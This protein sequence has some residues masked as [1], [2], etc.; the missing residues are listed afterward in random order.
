MSASFVGHREQSLY[1]AEQKA[2]VLQ[3]C[4]HTG[5]ASETDSTLVDLHPEGWLLAVVQPFAAVVVGV[6]AILVQVAEG[7]D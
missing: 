7:S 1:T 3:V 4:L 6:A 2:F 5:L